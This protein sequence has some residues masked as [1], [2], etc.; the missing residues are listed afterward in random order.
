MLIRTTC[1]FLSKLPH[2]FSRNVTAGD[3]GSAF[4]V[5]LIEPRSE[6]ILLAIVVVFELSMKCP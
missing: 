5:N 3:S 6:W 2:S 4:K 1:G